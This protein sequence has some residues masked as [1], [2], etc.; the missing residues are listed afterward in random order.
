MPEDK[1]L[2]DRPSWDDYFIE[3]AR[4]VAQRATCPRRH[5]GA[6]LVKDR[7]LV[8]SGYNGAVRGQPHCDEV[9]C[10]L[11]DGHCVR[12]VHAEV[13]A[14]I[15]C[16]LEGVSSRG[17]SAYTT[18]FPCVG[19]AKCLVQAGVVR[20][21]YLAPYPDLHSAPILTQGGIRV[22]HARPAGD[23]YALDEEVF[24]QGER[25]EGDHASAPGRASADA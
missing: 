25:G 9:G 17:A 22:Y 13:N 12:A 5:V 23:G 4:L 11:V 7:R 3:M 16:A 20:L 21:V 14:I 18:D 2:S 15:Q 10:L 8:A 6:V 1:G 24:S 19:C